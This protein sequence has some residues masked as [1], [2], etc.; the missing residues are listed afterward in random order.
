MKI[1]Q[2]N[3][4]QNQLGANRILAILLTTK[5]K[6]NSPDV[7]RTISLESQYPLELRLKYFEQRGLNC[8]QNP[9]RFIKNFYTFPTPT[10][11]PRSMFEGN[12]IVNYYTATIL[13]LK[14]KKKGK[15]A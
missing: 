3:Y 12:L 6:L 1:L 8:F 7:K 15:N 9:C 4:F 11:L 5:K 14:P 10:P 2:R 13:I